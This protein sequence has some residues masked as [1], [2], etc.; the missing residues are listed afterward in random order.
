MQHRLAGAALLMLA[1]VAAILIAN[2]PLAHTYHHF[3]ETRLTLDAGVLKLDHSIHH[4][5]NDGLMSIFFF[6]VGLE[7]K[8]ELL[9][10]ELCTVRK[11]TLPAIAA[12]G[13]MIVP[14]LF[15]A[16]F[17]AGHR[18]QAAG[19]FRWPQT[20]RFPW[21]FFPSWATAFLWA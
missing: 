13:G 19:G 6:F 4:W 8:R 17:N 2:S 9:I 12:L 7:I 16:A 21:G 3:L 10:G 15:F 1:T 18:Q 5:I 11:A 20:L 14:A